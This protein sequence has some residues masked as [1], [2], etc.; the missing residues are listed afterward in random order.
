MPT[1][2]RFPDRKENRRA[3]PDGEAAEHGENALDG[4]VPDHQAI[5]AKAVDVASV[6]S[7]EAHVSDKQRRLTD[8]TVAA[9]TDAG[10]MRL[11]S[12]RRQGGHEARP[13]TLFDVC[14]ELGH[15]CCSAAWVTSVL[16][17]GNYMAAHFSERAQ[18]E[19]WDG[20]KDTRT[21]LIIAPSR[22]AVER[23]DGGVVVSGEWGYASGSLHAEW[24]AA[25]I[26]KG[27]DRD[28]DTTNLV[29]MRA[30]EVEIRDT[31][32]ITGMRGTGSNTVVANRL[33]IPR[34]RVTPYA[35]IV[36]GESR[37][38][39]ARHPLYSGSYSGLLSLGLLGPQLGAIET[40]LRLVREQ[41]HE[42]R[43]ASST[44]RS[45]AISPAFQ[46]DIAE[47][48]LMIDGAKLHARRIVETVEEHALAGAL[49]DE[50]TRSR[51]RMES[52]R[53]TRLC[54]EAIDR[55]ITA[56]GSAAFFETNP[57]QLIWRDLHVA[58]RHAGFGM[59][60]P[61]LV[62][63]RALVGLDPREISYLV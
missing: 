7:E 31:W 53:V 28:D 26:P 56:Y 33:F 39:S 2:R 38:P 19:V 13:S 62:Y 29:L 17:M 11:F 12:P 59:G 25:L 40:A 8:R 57:L 14:V 48:A 24:I 58:S 9:V 63:G 54:R 10:L 34:H 3:S 51:F 49:P 6:L 47:A 36:T 50:L 52:T 5:V 16:N 1:S 15:G 22:A 23:V 27:V 45:Q 55:L 43:V 44:F 30:D 46:T 42:R 61:Q 35:P 21:A 37:P 41:A 4:S 18:D 60:I 32:H 20:N